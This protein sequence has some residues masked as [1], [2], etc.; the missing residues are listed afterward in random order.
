MGLCSILLGLGVAATACQ[1]KPAVPVAVSP[2]ANGAQH[3]EPVVYNGRPYEVSF[4]FDVA[5]K[6]YEVE[7]A[8]KDRNL[9]ASPGD[10]RIVEQVAAS[11][12]R[13]FAC[14][15]GQRGEIV[16]GSARH[17]GAAWAMRAR[18]S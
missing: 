14:P 8:G 16:P 1:E 15:T 5:A 10:Q 17:S 12:V 2:Y 11:T 6:H 3:T 13:H 4:R 7:V 18:C 9:G